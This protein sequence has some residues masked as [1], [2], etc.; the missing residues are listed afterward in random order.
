MSRSCQW[1]AYTAQVGHLGFVAALGGSIGLIVGGPIQLW[2]KL[3]DI[4][5]SEEKQKG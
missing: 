5:D 4:E 1:L 2:W 3:I